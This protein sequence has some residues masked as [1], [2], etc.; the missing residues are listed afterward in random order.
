MESGDFNIK[1]VLTNKLGFPL[2]KLLLKSY[3]GVAGEVLGSS[4]MDIAKEKITDC[5]S[6]K[7]FG[8]LAAWFKRYINS[9]GLSD[10]VYYRNASVASGLT[11]FV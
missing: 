9:S 8:L 2:A 7:P 3:F 6:S 5:T 10:F 11:C 4:L 1:E